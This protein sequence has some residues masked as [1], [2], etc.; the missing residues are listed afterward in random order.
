MKRPAKKPKAPP[1]IAGWHEDV[2]HEL[3]L[4]GIQVHLNTNE[5][6]MAII[7]MHAAAIAG[8]ANNGR[9]YSDVAIGVANDIIRLA[10]RIK[11]IAKGISYKVS[12]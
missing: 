8:M 6:A 12:R 5:E 4:K 7:H 3:I 1:E 11:F 2:N 9:D 10:D